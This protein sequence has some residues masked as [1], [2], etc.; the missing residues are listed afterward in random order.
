MTKLNSVR[1]GD[2]FDIAILFVLDKTG[3]IQRLLNTTQFS[4]QSS[5]IRICHSAY[6]VSY[7]QQSQI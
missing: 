1:E 2:R 5:G 3:S 4:V 6:I 7:H